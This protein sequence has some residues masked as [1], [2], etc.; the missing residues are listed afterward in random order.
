MGVKFVFFLGRWIFEVCCNESYVWS[1]G[2]RSGGVLLLTLHERI[3][4][5]VLLF[6]ISR[7]H[8]STDAKK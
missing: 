7:F 1:I 8:I 3:Y 2:Y 5:S 6:R 4:S